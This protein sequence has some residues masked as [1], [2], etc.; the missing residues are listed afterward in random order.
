M[1]THYTQFNARV[2]GMHIKI[3]YLMS[4]WC[5]N[6]ITRGVAVINGVLRYSVLESLLIDLFITNMT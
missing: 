4:M 2:N 1:R 5:S 3:V 6:S